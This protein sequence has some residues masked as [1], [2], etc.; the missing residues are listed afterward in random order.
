MFFICLLLYFNTAQADVQADVQADIQVDVKI[1]TVDDL[2]ELKRQAEKNNLPV[3][4]L[5]TAEYCGY[6]E[7]IRDEFLLPMI[8]SGDYDST[9]LIRQVYVESYHH[10]RNEKGEEITGDVLAQKYNIKLTPTIVFIDS[11]GKELTERLVGVGN[12]YYFGGTLD[13]HIDQAV[14]TLNLNSQ[15]LN[16][17][18]LNS[19]V[20]NSQVLNSQILNSRVLIPP[21]R[22]F[23]TKK[24]SNKVN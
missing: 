21:V 2:G 3:L 16:S 1:N 8:R 6:C 17:Q 10:L 9:I 11:E 12:V 23:Q 18:V 4:L 14:K 5:F 22:N 7:I 15:V 24:S 13:N 19:Q 20:L